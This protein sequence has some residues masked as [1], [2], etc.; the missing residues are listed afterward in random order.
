MT[1]VFTL[2]A[3]STNAVGFNLLNSFWTA[4][5]GP[6]SI[7]LQSRSL[8]QQGYILCLKQQH[9]SMFWDRVPLHHSWVVPKER[10]WPLPTATEAGQD[11]YP[12]FS[13]SSLEQLYLLARKKRAWFE[14]VPYSCLWKV[15][16]PHSLFLDVSSHICKVAYIKYSCT[17]ADSVWFTI[18]LAEH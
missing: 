15:W 1:K 14:S 18:C 11:Y 16:L 17:S 12:T 5:W 4:K 6:S 3:T 13:R 2:M 10:T 7:C 9:C 8:F